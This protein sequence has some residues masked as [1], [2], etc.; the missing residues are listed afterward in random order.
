MAYEELSRRGLIKLNHDYDNE[1]GNALKEFLN[2][3]NTV[4]EPIRPIE[5]VIDKLD[6][7]TEAMEARGSAVS[8]AILDR[9]NAMFDGIIDNLTCEIDRCTEVIDESAD[10]E[11]YPDDTED[12]EDDEEDDD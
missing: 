3:S 2:E 8:G 12:D 1:S 6:K 4:Y 7:T 10:D 5:Q 11:Q 9:V